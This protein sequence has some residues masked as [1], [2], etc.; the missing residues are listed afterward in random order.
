KKLRGLFMTA[1]GNSGNAA[2]R[3]EAFMQSKG[4]YAYGGYPGNDAPF[5]PQGGGRHAKKHEGTLFGNTRLTIQR[6]LSCP[7]VGSRARVG[8]RPA[9]RKAPHPRRLKEPVPVLRGRRAEA[10]AVRRGMPGAR[11]RAR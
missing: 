10:V 4:A 11:P 7:G 8:H 3:V 9:H 1:A 6:G 2:S 5:Q